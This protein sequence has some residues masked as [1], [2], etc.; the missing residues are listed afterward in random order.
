[1]RFLSKIQSRHNHPNPWRKYVQE[2]RLPERSRHGQR[3]TIYWGWGATSNF[4]GIYLPWSFLLRNQEIKKGLRAHF[5]G[6]QHAKWASLLPK[7]LRDLRTRKNAATGYMPSRALRG[8]Y[9]PLSGVYLLPV[10]E[11]EAPQHWNRREL[12]MFASS[13]S[14]IKASSKRWSSSTSGIS[15]DSKSSSI[16][17]L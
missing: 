13:N 8:Y 10:P 2:V 5:Q 6:Q 9:L 3:K 1:M 12:K 16:S 14:C 11:P 15:D 17:Y 7:V 4:T